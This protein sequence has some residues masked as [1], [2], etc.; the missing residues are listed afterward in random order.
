M[1]FVID[2][3][4]VK[5]INKIWNDPVWSKVIA[6]GILSAIT[7]SIIYFQK[8]EIENSMLL[9]IFF[10]IILLFLFAFLIRIIYHNNKK[11]TKLIVFVSTGGTC[12]D[13]IAKAITQKLLENRKIKFRIH[14]KGMA[15]I[16]V[17]G[18]KTSYAARV[19]I[20]RMYGTDLL[21]SHKPER[22]NKKDLNDASIILVMSDEVKKQLQ[23]RFPD[24][25]KN[26]NVYLL[27]EFFGLSG[28]IK[29]PYPDGKD[30]ETIFRYV[31]CANEM[32][33]ILSKNIDKLISAIEI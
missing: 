21:S 15:V 1:V 6:T 26:G 8:I 20:K 27:K 30:E 25:N 24:Y 17:K 19:A 22:I 3:N 14:I 12:R 18:F 7:I 23:L 33:Q 11:R 28:D 13:P 5:I 32:N 4:I 9:P 10:T 31:S 29:N 2:M 16:D